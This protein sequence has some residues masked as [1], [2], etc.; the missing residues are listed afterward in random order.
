MKKKL[1][2]LTK[3]ES[4]RLMDILPPPTV[5][6]TLIG[7]EEITNKADVK[8]EINKIVL[9]KESIA[10]HPEC[11]DQ[12]EPGYMVPSTDGT[13]KFQPFMTH[14]SEQQYLTGEKFQEKEDGVY[15]KRGDQLH[16][17]TNCHIVLIGKRSVWDAGNETKYFRCQVFC[18][19]WGNDPREMEV[20]GKSYKDIFEKIR[21]ECQE[22]SIS[23]SNP[24]ALDEYLSIVFQNDIDHIPVINEAKKIGWNDCGGQIKYFIGSDDYYASYVSPD[25]NAIIA[26]APQIFSD[27]ARFLQVGHNNN[28]ISLLFLGSMLA[29]S[30]FWMRKGHV[31]FRQ[32]FYLRGD[33]N[34]LKS[35]T[36]A[37]IA[38]IF[39]SNREKALSRITSTL[40][41]VQKTVALL[42]DNYLCFDDFSNTEGTLRKKAIETSES[43]IRAYGDGS[44]PTKCNPVNYAETLQDTVQNT[45]VLIG[46]EN[47]PLGRSSY[48]RMIILPIEEGTFDGEE[49]NFFQKNP[50]ILQ[51][52]A[53][54][55]ITFL[56][57]HGPDVIT[58][59]KHK[60]DEYRD[61]FSNSLKVRRSI[62]S[63]VALNIQCDI[64]DSFASWCDMSDMWQ[65][66][67]PNFKDSILETLQQNEHFSQTEKPELRFLK[68]FMSK[69]RTK[70]ALLAENEGIY[71]DNEDSFIG[72]YEHATDT[73]WVRFDE[74]WKLVRNYYLTFDE[75]W[76]QQE[77][78]IKRLLVQ[79]GFAV[80]KIGKKGESSVYLMKSKKEPRRYMLVLNCQKVKVYLDAKEED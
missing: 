35:S 3:E 79:G 66:A 78:T 24:D 29:Y 41:G 70:G 58:L 36:M 33:T 14:I 10:Q 32:V 47:I 2:V 19:V 55:Y 80:G 62:D 40:A 12:L 44:F 8:E 34:L 48:T 18:D 9:P 1:N 21:S 56:T 27:G 68:A 77:K 6:G 69:V 67:R 16:K 76:L 50:Q 60:Q 39:Q 54:L 74:V 61:L 64:L 28:V 23:R 51:N 65:A 22:I 42:P 72:F 52:F 38:N 43:L 25:Q 7:T 57:E 37:V 26:N 73:M 75:S 59:C 17:L 4:K 63:A 46:E 45:A 31:D 5:T 15:A 53:A 30:L 11:Q 13:W 20:E 49:L 71:V